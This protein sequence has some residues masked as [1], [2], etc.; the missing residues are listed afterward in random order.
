MAGPFTPNGATTAF[1]FQFKIL[2]ADEVEVSTVFGGAETIVPPSQYS[3]TVSPG[4]GG[5]VT[6]TSPPAAGGSPIYIKPN[7]RFEQPINYVENG[8]DRA[9][10]RNDAL[11][12]GVVRDL[13]L[14]N[15]LRR[16]ILLPVGEVTSAIA[17]AAA[18]RANKVLAFDYL[19]QPTIREPIGAKGDPGGNVMA[20]GLFAA[21][22]A[23]SIPV[24]TDTIQTSGH[25]VKVDGQGLYVADNAVD[26][27][28]VA[29][30]PRT[31]FVSANG[32]GFR[33]DVRQ[34]LNILMFGAVGDATK[35]TG[36]DDLPAFN[37]MLNFLYVY[38]TAA[39]DGN[40]NPSPL[41]SGLMTVTLPGRWYR[42]SSHIKVKQGGIH[43]IGD[44]GALI[45]VDPGH[46]GII[47]EDYSTDDE[48]VA[49]TDFRSGG[50]IYDNIG[51]KTWG[52]SLSDP[53]HGWWVRTTC[54]FRHCYAQNFSGNA[55]NFSNSV[56]AGGAGKGNSNNANLL[57]CGGYQSGGHGLFMSGGDTNAMTL[58]HFDG[59]NNAG[60]GVFEN[61]FL[62]NIHLGHHTDGNGWKGSGPSY[63]PKTKTPGASYGGYRWLV[64]AGSDATASTETPG[65]G[66][67]WI[68]YQVDS[69]ADQN[70]PTWVSGGS[71]M[72]G[73]SIA[74]ININV[75]SAF[76]L[77]YAE[78][79]QPPAQINQPNQNFGGMQNVGLGNA[80]EYRN[81]NQGVYLNRPIRT[82]DADALGN[83]TS[84]KMG[85]AGPGIYFAWY[86]A[87][88]N[89]AG[90]VIAQEAE[91]TCINS[92][93]L[94]V[95]G[96]TTILG[97]TP[98]GSTGQFGRAVGAST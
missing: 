86:H 85:P 63:A 81:D 14:W 94:R 1:P 27:A 7:P 28:F 6:F 98:Q 19:G 4:E 77:C 67:S 5:T 84:V 11:D 45:V 79:N 82:N 87:T 88:L 13:K 21:A 60:Y 32:R 29:N 83:A 31:S 78:N 43:L 57:F 15:M 10:T 18:D 3:V 9:K 53:K 62:G 44:A 73:G 58:Q 50:G 54:T 52:G 96:G 70:F 26:A 39:M 65:T 40:G 20:I 33:L 92:K 66:S 34:P 59:Q 8:P 48:T 56:G 80:V 23:L 37:A 97:F 24:G 49:S 38:R 12:A 89:A 68:K 95:N 47:I 72:A 90:T 36:T 17:I 61:S 55:W 69:G 25:T 22:S 93:D 16:A 30:H 91:G 75:G 51:F 74:A 64:R 76:H 35:T 42:I 2:S 71:Y 41:V 46:H